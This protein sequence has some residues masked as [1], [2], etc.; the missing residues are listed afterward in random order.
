MTDA[1]GHK[2]RPG[3]GPLSTDMLIEGIPLNVYIHEN[4]RTGRVEIV[5]PMP[6]NQDDKVLKE[7]R[8]RASAW[9]WA[10]QELQANR[11]P[12]HPVRG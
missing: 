2:N 12:A 3:V 5:Q 9:E 10:K 8:D 4:P 7:F 6:R 11:L 1:T